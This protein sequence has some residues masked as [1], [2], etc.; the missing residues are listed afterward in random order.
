MYKTALTYADSQALE[1]AG[2]DKSWPI[3]LRYVRACVPCARAG[4][5]GGEER[6]GASEGSQP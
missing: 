4:G 5:R 6:R 3:T 1:A 2:L